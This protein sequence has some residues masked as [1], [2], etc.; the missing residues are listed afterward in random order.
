MSFGWT[1]DAM[2]DGAPIPAAHDGMA[3][4]ATARWCA[5]CV[6]TSWAPGTLRDADQAPCDPA[7]AGGTINLVF[8]PRVGE[9]L[10][11]LPSLSGT[12]RN[13]AGGPTSQGSWLRCEETTAVAADGS[14]C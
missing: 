10:E 13:C 1:G 4:S 9:W 8:D 2:S 6:T 14:V 12:I 3:A 5:S 7:A 11:S